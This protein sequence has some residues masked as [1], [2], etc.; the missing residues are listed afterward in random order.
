MPM[1]SSRWKEKGIVGFGRVDKIIVDSPKRMW[2]K[3]GNLNGYN[4]YDE[5]ID[6]ITKR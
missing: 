4:T 1:P 5:F 3:Y 6:A 2:K